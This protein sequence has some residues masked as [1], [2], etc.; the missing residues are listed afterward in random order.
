MLLGLQKGPCPE[1]GPFSF[2]IHS[3]F[4][5]VRNHRPPCTVPAAPPKCGAFFL[6][7]VHSST[8]DT[9]SRTECRANSVGFMPRFSHFNQERLLLSAPVHARVSG[10]DSMNLPRAR[11]ATP[12]RAA[13]HSSHAARSLQTVP[14]DVRALFCKIAGNTDPLRRGI[15]SNSDPSDVMCQRPSFWPWRPGRAGGDDWR[16]SDRPDTTRLF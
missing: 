8:A 13:I 6:S 12:R 10:I 11:N 1:R 14:D 2:R 15:A 4:T 5:A 7:P 16:G 3:S 9:F